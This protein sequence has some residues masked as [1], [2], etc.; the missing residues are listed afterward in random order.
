MNT[1]EHR[2]WVL[3]GLKS[4]KICENLCPIKKDLDFSDKLL[5]GGGGGRVVLSLSGHP[6]I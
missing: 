5:V 1:D 3:L 6:T 2:F 4:V